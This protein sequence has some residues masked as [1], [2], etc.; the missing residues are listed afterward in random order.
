[1][2]SELVVPTLPRSWCDQDNRTEMN[3]G[4]IAFFFIAG[5]NRRKNEL[6]A[7]YG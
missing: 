2:L 3:E 4:C 1:M 5:L 6:T 7:L